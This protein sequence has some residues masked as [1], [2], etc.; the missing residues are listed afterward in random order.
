M[1]EDSQAKP[2]VKLLRGA[3]HDVKTI[4]EICLNGEPDSVV[5]DYAKKENRVL[6]THNCRDFQTLHSENPNH[7]GILAVYK[8]D[9]YSQDMSRGDI[10]KAI[11]NLEATNIC[12]VN[13]FI[14]LNPWNY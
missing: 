12:L 9:D 10:V 7:P 5:L 2:L 11:A 8:N 6:F 4:N 3:G 14:P 13:E 1:D